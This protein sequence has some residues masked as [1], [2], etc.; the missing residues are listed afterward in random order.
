[1]N[2][3]KIYQLIT[4]KKAGII[5]AADE[6]LLEEQLESSPRAR[7]LWDEISEGKQLQGPAA[8]LSSYSFTITPEVHSFPYIKVIAAAF[9]FTLGTCGWLWFHRP[10][11]A[12]DMAAAAP[13]KTRDP[14]EKPVQL[15]LAGG[16]TIDLSTTDKTVHIGTTE[17]Q[18]QDNQLLL[19]SAGSLP[20][21]TNTLT[22][23]A[24]KSY[25]MVFADSSEIWINSLTTIHFPFRFKDNNRDITV[26]GEAYLKISRNA[27]QP[28]I[29]RF[30]G[31][32]V[33]VLG[34]GFNVNAYDSNR[35]RISLVEGRVKVT[36]GQ[37]NVLLKP[38]QQAIYLRKT[39]TLTV[40]SF[41][42]QEELGWR[43]RVF[44]VAGVSLL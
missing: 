32:R 40:S 36:A 31:G 35:I 25:K 10:L 17:L 44:H 26:N 23:P 34:T 8:W 30:P 3:G 15:K 28:F 37:R 38:G 18:N 1:M 21:G 27:V 2:L 42:E 7:Q 19:T 6:E 39:G 14:N 22:V 11:P 20:E 9:I 43:N 29:V 16:N 33:E 5:S 13:Q 24:G 41:E 12:T 4:E